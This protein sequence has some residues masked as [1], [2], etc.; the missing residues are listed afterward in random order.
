MKFLI[1]MLS[2]SKGISSKRSAMVWCILLFT[3]L[4]IV[5]VY[6]G[7]HPDATFMDDLRELNRLLVGAVVG[8]KI[9]AAYMNNIGEKKRSISPSSP[10]QTKPA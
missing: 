6:T 10:D 2:G 4:I 1:E 8:E 9:V 5:N 3:F 7:K